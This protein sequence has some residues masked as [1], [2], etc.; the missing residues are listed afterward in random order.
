MVIGKGDSKREYEI[1]VSRLK[2]ELERWTDYLDI[3][4]LIEDIIQIGQECSVP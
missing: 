1:L 4:S 2:R 3:R